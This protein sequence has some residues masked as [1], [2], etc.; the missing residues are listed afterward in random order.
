MRD[1]PAELRSVYRFVKGKSSSGKLFE[2]LLQALVVS[3]VLT[4]TLETLRIPLAFRVALEL[5]E[6]FTVL[7]FSFE[8]APTPLAGRISHTRAPLVSQKEFRRVSC[9]SYG[10]SL[11]IATHDE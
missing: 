10:L 3:S 6:L 1:A 4:F 5:L 7:V 11:M 9:V 2:K 8:Y